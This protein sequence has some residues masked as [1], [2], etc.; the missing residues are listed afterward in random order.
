MVDTGTHRCPPA[1]G[2]RRGRWGGPSATDVAPRTDRRASPLA[3][4]A[5]VAAAC[6]IGACA[7]TSSP[8]GD[9]RALFD[10]GL[11][12]PPSA[13]PDTTSVFALDADMQRYLS[14]PIAT[15]ARQ[16]GAQR[17]LY[18]TLYAG[19]KELRVDFDASAT[20][21]AADTFHTR[22]GNCLSLVL[23]TAAFAK[24]LDLTVNFQSPDVDE[25]WSRRGGFTIR[26]GHVN[27][28]LG[29]R[30]L[31]F[32][33]RMPT[34]ELTIDFVPADQLQGLHMRPVSEATLLAM[35]MNNRAVEALTSGQLDDAYWWVREGLL[36]DPAF[37]GALNTLGVVYLRRDAPMQAERALRRVLERDD[38]N[39][40]ALSNLAQVLDRRSRPAEAA[41][42]RAQLKALE[43]HA[44]YEYFDR[45]L[46]AAR[47][48]DW[49]QA[50]DLFEREVRRPNFDPTVNHW[51]AV[52]E[53]RLGHV[54]AARRQLEQA[55]KSGA[56][57][58][59]R[60]LYGAKL[61]WLRRH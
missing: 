30:R 10:D 33:Q 35:Y 20:R 17:A 54:E 24:A 60:A 36:A 47:D 48:G 34:S 12:H 27:V 58:D 55:V 57:P 9:A 40:L 38:G 1:A 56:T 28:T 4:L 22:S 59:E 14:G 25:V 31:V 53:Y 32:P 44:A 46:V 18:D 41:A 6:V 50:R 23:L 13:R 26:N 43:P 3:R 8:H 2:H 52:A 42:V 7:S 21:T 19:G 11:F 45:G 15:K 39:T 29:P 61:E 5:A 49:A 37:A 51:L 16:V